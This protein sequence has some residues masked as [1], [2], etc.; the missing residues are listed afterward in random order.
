MALRDKAVGHDSISSFF[1]KSA[2]HVITSFLQLFIDFMFSEGCFP[3]SCKIARITPIYKNGARDETNNHRSIFILTCFSK[4][5]EKLVYTR[6]IEFFN[7]HGVIY[8]N[9]FGFQRRF[10]RM[11]ATLDVVACHAGYEHICCNQHTGLVLIDLKK[12]FHTVSHKT[13]PVK[14]NNY[15]IRGVAY[16]LIYSYLEKRMQYV[17]L[18]QI[19]S[20]LQNITFGVPQGSSL[21]PLFFLIHIN[22]LT[23]ALQSKPRLFADDTCPISSADTLSVL[24]QK[25]NA[26]LKRLQVWCPVNELTINLSKTCI[27]IVPPKS[28]RN[29][30]LQSEHMI[31]NHFPI[32]TVSSVKYLG[33]YLDD[34]LNF[35]E[36]IKLLESK[37]RLLGR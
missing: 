6:L 30:N 3:N 28:K 31:S 17:E 10:S 24:H 35:K 36:H 2:R 27:R 4:I 32:K 7:K 1:P 22:D 16:K 37:V 5:I 9:Q 26:E 23:N 25:I 18:N 20:N 33:V 15:G 19:R 21:G 34:E 8:E 13:L 14:L 12:T 11:H 29:I